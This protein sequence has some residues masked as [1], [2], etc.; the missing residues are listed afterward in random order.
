M[1]QGNNMGLCSEWTSVCYQAVS[2]T[3]TPQLWMMFLWQQKLACHAKRTSVLAQ[4]RHIHNRKHKKTDVLCLSTYNGYTTYSP[5]TMLTQDNHAAMH[6]LR[7]QCLISAAWRSHLVAFDALA[8]AGTV[9]RGRLE[10]EPLVPTSLAL[11]LI[12][13]INR[14]H[15]AQ[16]LACTQQHGSVGHEMIMHQGNPFDAV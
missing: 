3:L 12:S 16:R 7:Q 1:Q 5:Q 9:Q 14:R 13:L 4:A 10:C 8:T 15:I 2:S 6:E 11:I